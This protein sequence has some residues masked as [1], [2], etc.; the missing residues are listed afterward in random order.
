MAEFSWQWNRPVRA[1]RGRRQAVF[2]T[3]AAVA[4]VLVGRELRAATLTA[5]LDHNIVAAGESVTLTLKF[6]GGSPDHLAPPPQVPNLQITYAGGP[7]HIDININGQSSSIDSYNFN[8][9][10]TQPGDYVI[11]PI[12]AEVNGQILTSQPLR[13]KAIKP[14]SV[15]GQNT[16]QQLAFWKL[17]VPKKEIYLGEVIQPQV[18]LFIRSGVVNAE[19][20]LQRF[21]A[22]APSLLKAEGFS[23]LKSA[24]AH[25]QQL[26]VDNGIYNVATLVTCLSPVKTGVLAVDVASARLGLQLPSSNRQRDF[27]DPF[28]ML[29]QYREQRVDLAADEE[30]ITVLP[31]PPGAP[32]NFNGA[33]GTFQ[34]NVTAGPTNVAVGDPITVKIRL[35]GTGPL[36][37]LTLPDQ[38]AW[39]NFKIYPPAPSVESTDPLGATGT[40]TFETVVVP[41]NPD[42]RSL[43]PVS[44]SYFDSDKRQYESLTGPAIA[45]TVR[46][47]GTTV[48]PAAAGTAR[49]APDAAASS[50]DIVTIKQR[51]GEVAEIGPPLLERPWFLG[52]QGVPALALVSAV[53]WRK[54][55]DRLANNP[56]LRRRRQVARLIRSGMEELRKSA[57]AN[58]SDEFF[59]TLVRLLQEQ[60]GDCLDLPAAAITEAVI[61]DRLRPRGIPEPTLAALRELFQSCNLARYAPAQSGQEL[62]AL[63]PKLDAVLGQLQETVS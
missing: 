41:Q 8:V 30:K 51:L 36:D 22:V 63:I 54:R 14:G 12:R 53:A 13:L 2:C 18:Q 33:V 32:A 15:P 50:R 28:G 44:F 20:I 34:L 7:M 6:E 61:E 45:L 11:P 29:P 58:R 1:T 35:S 24:P 3:V 49:A 5:S 27:F 19:D 57:A 62:V 31:L 56:R 40:K 37:S 52:M 46:P 59:A 10:P 16:D 39:H 9:T 38:P 48:V 43:P 23:V 60:L 55:R 17:V 26:Q 25:H 42:I 21:D 4:A 47:G